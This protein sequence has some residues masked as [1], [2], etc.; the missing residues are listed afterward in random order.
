MSS[1]ITMSTRG[2]P[3]LPAEVVRRPAE[4][5]IDSSINVVVVLPFVP[6]THN[7]SAGRSWPRSRH[8]SSNSPHT[9]TPAA[10]AAT[11]TSA[12]GGRPG[13][14]TRTSAPAAC[15]CA[16]SG[17]FRPPR[18]TWAPSVRRIS[19]R[20]CCAS[21]DESSTTVICAPNCSRASAHEYP[22]IP[23]PATVTRTE[24]QSEDRCRSSTGE[25]LTLAPTRRRRGSTR[26]RCTD[27]ARSTCAPRSGSPASRSSRSDGAVVPSGTRAV[28]ST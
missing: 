16:T 11:M 15:S 4:R 19:A 27:P 8:A 9:G 24:D 7:H 17:S 28:R 12:R 22:A 18:C 20:C 3:M 5:S 26:L 13:D 23:S 2:L 6:V 10:R 14:T 25:R 1:C 21:P